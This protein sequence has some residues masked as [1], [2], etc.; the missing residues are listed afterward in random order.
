M[1]PV[2]LVVLAGLDEDESLETAREHW[3]AGLP[4]VATTEWPWTVKRVCLSVGAES[5]GY[6][7]PSERLRTWE[8]LP[9]V[10]DSSIVHVC[11]PYTRAGEIAILAGNA[12]S[13][14]V[15]VSDLGAE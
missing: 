6:P 4:G 14:A 12:V 8:V 11:R 10:T 9:A 13:R 1:T 15:G 3:S 7:V 2:V 5:T